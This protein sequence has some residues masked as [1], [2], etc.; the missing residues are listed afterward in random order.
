[1][2]AGYEIPHCHYHIFSSDSNDD[3]NNV[4]SRKAEPEELT[5]MQEKIL[6][7]LE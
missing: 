3:L 4:S 7:F 5:A 1:M 6:S 2:F